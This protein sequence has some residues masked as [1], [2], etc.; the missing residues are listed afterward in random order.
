MKL[1]FEPYRIRIVEKI[2]STTEVER[3]N[4]LRVV[5]YNLL[6]IPFPTI[7]VDL[8]SDLGI[9]ALDISQFTHFFPEELTFTHMETYQNLRKTVDSLFGF[10]NVIPTPVGRIA[11]MVLALSFISLNSDRKLVVS[12]RISP[13]HRKNLERAGMEIMEI[14]GYFPFEDYEF[15]GDIDTEKLKKILKEREKEIAFVSITLTDEPWGFPVSIENIKA[16]R[17]ITESMGVLLVADCSRFAENLYFNLEEGTLYEK[18]FQYGVRRLFENFDLITLSGR[19]S[20]F[21]FSG[22]LLAF[23]E[24]RIPKDLRRNFRRLTEEM[25]GYPTGGGLS[26][27]ELAMMESGLREILHE[28]SIAHRIEQVGYLRRRLKDMG[29]PIIPS[30][31]SYSV[32]IRAGEFIPEKKGKFPALG[33]NVFLYRKFAI[34]G[35]EIIIKTNGKSEE[36]LTLSV[37]KRIYT[38]SH[39]EYVAEAF[40][41]MIESKTKIRGFSKLRGN[42]PSDVNAEFQPL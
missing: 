30:R 15:K 12:N 20:A 14:P 27:K 21:A 29:Y 7:I 18:S 33:I 10:D 26:G 6:N 28:E 1:K 4:Y 40:S 13:V 5:G 32:F 37:P 22:G 41:E 36:F 42:Y 35:R 16:T 23:S 17:E 2:K 31:S 8:F 11:S 25:S 38:N 9:S 34:R 19:K 3:E 24:G 39:I